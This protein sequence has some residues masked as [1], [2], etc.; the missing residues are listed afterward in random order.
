MANLKQ[1]A[2][3]YV[4]MG[5]SIFPLSAR[6]KEPSIPSWT[7]YRISHAPAESVSEWWTK[8][9]E[10]NIGL[11]TGALNKIVV[12]DLDG[13]EGLAFGQSKKLFSPVTSLTGNGRQL[14]Y[15][16][17]DGVRNS[18]G[19]IAPGVDIRGEG[20]YV[21]AP[22][23]VHP[24]GRTYRWMTHALGA[25]KLPEF[26]SELLI[27]TPVISGTVVTTPN[28]S[29]TSWIA[30]NL[31]NLSE[32]N[33]NDTFF[34]IAARLHRD[35][36]K[37]ADIMALLTPYAEKHAFNGTELRLCTT[38][39]TG[40]PLQSRADQAGPILIRTWDNSRD[41]YEKRK[42]ETQT[43]EFETGFRVFTGLINGYQRKELSIIAAR[44]GVGKTN[45]VAAT[46][47]Q[48][49]NSH[50]TL[51]FSTETPFYRLYDRIGLDTVRNGLI[52]V[53]DDSM[54]TLDGIRQAVET[55][56]AEIVI[57]DHINHISEDYETL[58]KYIHGL[59]Q[60]A[61]QYDI[62]VIV[63]AQLSRQAD[64]VDMRTGKRV[65]SGM[66]MI[67][68]SGTIEQIAAHVL[69][70]TEVSRDEKQIDLEARVVKNRYGEVGIFYLRLLRNPWRL[71]S[72]E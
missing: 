11:P 3:H 12:V 57:F 45:F 5:F 20:G 47:R 61:T 37:F 26:P 32:G 17:K 56:K 18:A 58:S 59:K 28:S 19:K 22:S 52:S 9:P 65:T 42:E 16:W 69:I 34:R 31:K 1:A 60:I 7:S 40:Y 38:S 67:K 62:P 14:F 68:G 53:V 27:V 66:H 51:I 21:V 72:I 2:L 25:V 6:T 43:V 39:A 44:T 48:L 49:G 54:P 35:G 70:I 29:E 41:E 36:L 46:A 50:R 33:R 71:E 8:A 23:S 24:N 13:P 10:S 4:S 15:Q 55:S 64:Q 63:T 30:E